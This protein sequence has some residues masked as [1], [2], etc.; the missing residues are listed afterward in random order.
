MVKGV[1]GDTDTSSEY[2]LFNTFLPFDIVVKIISHL[3]QDNCLKCMEVCRA[4]YRMI[5]EYSYNVWSRININPL[6][7]Q[8][9]VHN[10]RWRRLLGNHVKHVEI[11]DFQAEQEFYDTMQKL[12]EFN[13]TGI[14]HLEISPCHSTKR[15]YKQ[16]LS[17]LKQLLSQDGQNTTHQQQLIICCSHPCKLPILHIILEACPQVQ[18]FSFTLLDSILQ[19]EDDDDNTTLDPRLSL[20]PIPSHRLTNLTYLNINI[21]TIKQQ[22][23]LI[24][25]LQRSPHLEFLFFGGPL[26]LIDITIFSAWFPKLVYLEI[27]SDK[28]RIYDSNRYLLQRR[29]LNNNDHDDR[30]KEKGLRYFCAPQ[31]EDEGFGPAQIGPLLKQH[32][33]TLEYIG[34][35]AYY[36]ATQTW[37]PVFQ[38]LKLT[39]LHTLHCD[40]ILFDDKSMRTLICEATSL[41]CLAIQGDYKIHLNLTKL[42]KSCLQL[43][44]LI[45]TQGM[46]SFDED[47]AQEEDPTN[48]MIPSSLSPEEHLFQYL[49]LN[50]SQLSDI[51]LQN[52]NG[53]NDEFMRTITH[54]STLKSLDIVLGRDNVCTDDGLFECILKLQGTTIQVLD[55][56]GIRHLSPPMC[57]AIA[58]L[59]FLKSFTS[60]WYDEAQVVDGPALIKMVEKSESLTHIQL[61]HITVTGIEIDNQDRDVNH[62]NLLGICLTRQLNGFTVTSLDFS[63]YYNI[64]IAKN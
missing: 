30:P 43:K 60:G 57:D 42:L 45:F 35:G 15:N 22:S 36:D 47:K 13:C 32:A 26:S 16:F 29:I 24:P 61:N 19:E 1:D 51:S 10:N 6:N 3:D 9:L 4:W 8:H 5:P 28:V 41:Q 50:G 46:L 64:Y 20:A 27:N 56:Y 12:V 33:N 52:V 63:G 31:E 37:A 59:K 18:K 48:N 2:R 23:I 34:L 53:I 44:K 62:E 58:N 54:L 14:E 39:Q 17:L 49:D 40:G 11:S 25:L 38:D 21:R 55:I 7:H